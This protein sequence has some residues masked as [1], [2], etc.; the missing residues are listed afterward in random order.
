MRHCTMY[1]YLAISAQGAVAHT[2]ESTAII[3]INN[4]DLNQKT[5][6]QSFSVL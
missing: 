5:Y 1:V 2:N 4:I 6:A 3:T